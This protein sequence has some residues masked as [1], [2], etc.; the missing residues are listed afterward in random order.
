LVYIKVWRQLNISKDGNQ[1]Y[2]KVFRQ[3]RSQAAPLG[4]A[5]ATYQI[6]KNGN[7]Y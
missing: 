6:P 7:S 3:G 2:N 1:K 4:L 5:L